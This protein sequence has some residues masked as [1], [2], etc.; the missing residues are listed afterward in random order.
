MAGI[1]R[2]PS[3][4]I[5]AIQIETDIPAKGAI[6]SQVIDANIKADITPNTLSHTADFPDGNILISNIAQP[7][8]LRLFVS[9]GLR[10]KLS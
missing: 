8:L 3:P 7:V 10:Q 4:I 9:Q 5:K 6:N 2:A 1:I